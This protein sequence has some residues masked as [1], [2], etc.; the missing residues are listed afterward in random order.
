MLLPQQSE[1]ST[2]KIKKT[3]SSNCNESG[4][5]FKFGIIVSST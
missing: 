4:R 2:I 3:L 1:I 5:V